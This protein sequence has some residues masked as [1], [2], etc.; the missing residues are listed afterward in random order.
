MKYAIVEING[1]QFWIETGKY[2]NLNKIPTKL[3]SQI[4]FN[5]ILLLNNN[6]NV[7][8]GKPHLEN[9][10]ISAKILTHFQKK[11]TIIYKMRPKK[12]TRKKKGY[13]QELT[14]VLI[15]EIINI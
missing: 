9:I 6:G 12:K 1:K 11:K 10:K 2:Y 4:I 8:V 13:R 15:N 14:K 7:L 5:R 3:G